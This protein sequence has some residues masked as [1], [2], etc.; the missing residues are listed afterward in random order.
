MIDMSRR[1]IGLATEDD[2]TA[3]GIEIPSLR[4][5]SADVGSTA[6]VL[7]RLLLDRR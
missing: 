5:P 3:S 7:A 1:V 2:I 6:A 4:L